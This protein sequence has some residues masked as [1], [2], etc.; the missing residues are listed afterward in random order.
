MNEV[1]T[2]ARFLLPCTFLY[3]Y[4]PFHIYRTCGDRTIHELTS[5]FE[6]KISAY[7]R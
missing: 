3:S 4:E 2:M 1:P 7:D 6:R 5:K